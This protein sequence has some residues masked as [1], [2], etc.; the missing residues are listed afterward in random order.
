MKTH[1]ILVFEDQVRFHVFGFLA[2]MPAGT[3]IKKV[4]NLCDPLDLIRFEQA[5]Y[6]R[7]VLFFLVSLSP[8]LTGTH[9]GF[10]LNFSS[11]C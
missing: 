1:L 5:Y 4:K 8:F 7:D 9:A 11:W 10:T 6:L 3:K 2:E